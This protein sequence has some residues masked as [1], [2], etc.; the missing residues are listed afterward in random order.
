MGNLLIKE[1]VNRIMI[2]HPTIKTVCTLSP[3][4]N[5]ASWLISAIKLFL[6]KIKD[7]KNSIDTLLLDSEWK[8]F[9]QDKYCAH[10]EFLVNE[11]TCI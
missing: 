10:E 9:D 2:N 5:F 11:S 1:S 4:P 8:R 3:I 6:I 7:D